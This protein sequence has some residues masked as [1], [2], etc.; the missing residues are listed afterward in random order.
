MLQAPAVRDEFI[1]E[2]VEEFGMAR[3]AATDTEIAGRVH[4]TLAEMV[5]PETVHDH[6]SGEWVVGMRDPIR[7]RESALGFGGILIAEG[8]GG[9]FDP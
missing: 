7:E 9:V 6:T 2:V 5:M 8:G 1:R 3:W 4:Q